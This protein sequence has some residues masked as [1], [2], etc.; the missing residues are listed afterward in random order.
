MKLLI[1]IGTKMI[2]V[3]NQKIVKIRKL[4]SSFLIKM[5]T[6]DNIENLIVNKI[7]ENV[8]HA[9]YAGLDIIMWNKPVNGGC[10]INM[11]K[12]AKQGV[13][14]NDTPKNFKSWRE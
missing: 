10:M 8:S 4:N 14:K 13:T 5:I 6:E 2:M 3:R 12:L 7:D 9:K 1:I 11:T